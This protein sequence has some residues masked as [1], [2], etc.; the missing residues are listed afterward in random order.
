VAWFWLLLPTLNPWYWTWAVPFLPFSRSRAWLAVSGLAF[1]YY[2]RFWLVAHFPNGSILGT[3][4][5]GAL[6]F[7]YIITWIEFGPWF[8]W[9]AFEAVSHRNR[10]LDHATNN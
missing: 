9:L 1:T 3:G 10:I 8:V 5:N 7:D 4:Y 2:F 6:F